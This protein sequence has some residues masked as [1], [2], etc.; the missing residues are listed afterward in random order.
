MLETVAENYDLGAGISSYETSRGHRNR[1]DVGELVEQH[2]AD[3]SSDRVVDIDKVRKI[4]KE[5]YA[6]PGIESVPD[7][8][9]A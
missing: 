7:L 8:D 2:V 3:I 4:E 1:N 5:Q 9:L 6:V